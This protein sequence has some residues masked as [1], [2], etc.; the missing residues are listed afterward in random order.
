MKIG[1]L[2]DSHDNLP[3]IEAAL[4]RFADAGVSSILHAG[5]LVAPFAAKLLTGPLV[6]DGVRVHAVL[7]NNDGER[8]G[9][10][11]VLP[12]IR[13]GVIRLDLGGRTVVMAHDGAALTEGDIAGADVVVT[14]HTHKV[15]NVHVAGVLQLNPGECGGW[16]TGRCT[17]ALLDPET[18]TA[19][20]I[21]L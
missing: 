21:D 18:L 11:N 13:E 4:R 2:S 7:G 3:K 14:G 6:K 5:D 12:G 8:Y 10:G 15:V 16:L 20:I 1:V 19:E 17:A 9:L